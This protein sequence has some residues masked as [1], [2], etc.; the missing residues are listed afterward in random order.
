MIG[1]CSPDWG[2]FILT[3]R[4]E[5]LTAA[6]QAYQ[7]IQRGNGGDPLAGR[8]LGTHLAAAGFNHIR[9]DACYER[10]LRAERIAGYLARQLI[11]AGED[12][13]AQTLRSWAADPLAMFAQS[14]VSATAT[15]SG[16]GS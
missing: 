6:V 15:R 7:E 4:S 5:A 14:W 9:L 11:D 16:S 3:P 13:H 10:Y 1:V 12:R 8:R 2:G